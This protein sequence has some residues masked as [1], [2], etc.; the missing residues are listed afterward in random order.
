MTP[1]FKQIILI[2]L[3]GYLVSCH[4]IQERTVDKKS[5]AA[6][7]QNADTTNDNR[8]N[9]LKMQLQD[10]DSILLLGHEKTYGP[11]INK[12]D[13]SY[14]EAK[15]IVENGVINNKV[16]K[17]TLLIKDQDKENLINILT[18]EVKGEQIV[19]ATCFDPHHALIVISKGQ[20]GY[21]EFCFTC[22]G[23]SADKVDISSGDFD[24]EKW[25]KIYKYIDS[26]VSFK[27]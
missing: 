27:E 5:Q 1:L 4:S 26:K 15:K 20:I 23:V 13:D 2:L 16:I 7:L 9:K 21:I 22:G 14:K 24:K 19:L 18:Q 17:E 3:S 6:S 8:F 25:D 11:I 12:K 10:S